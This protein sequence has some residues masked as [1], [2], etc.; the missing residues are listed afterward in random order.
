MK[1][2]TKLTLFTTVSKAVIV[3]LFVGLLPSMVDSV[4]FNYTN[5]LL[6]QQEKKVFTTIEKNGIDYYLEG[7][8]SYGSYTMLKEEYISLEQNKS[9]SLPDTLLTSKRMIEGDTLTYRLLIRNFEYEG[10]SYTLEIGKTLASINQYNR[11]LQRIALYV[12]LVLV[13]LTLIMDLGFTR[14]L[15]RPLKHIIGSKLEAPKF[16][17]NEKLEPIR[18]ST[19]DFR[20]LDQSLINLMH[21]ITEDFERERAFT[22]NA[23]HELM[24]PLGILQGKMENIMLSADDMEV[25]EKTSSMM[26]TLGRLKKIVNALLMISRIENNQYSRQDK[27]SP[28][29]LLTEMTEELGLLMKE[30]EI[31]SDIHLAGNITVQSV[32]QDLLF[33]LFYNLLTNAI[34]YNRK[35][36]RITITGKY[37][38]KGYV[39]T[40]EDTGIGMEAEELVHIFDRFRKSG[41]SGS[42]SNGL[43]L[44]IVKSIAE[45]HGIS[46]QVVSVKDR[47]SQFSVIFPMAMITRKRFK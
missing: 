14:V 10:K 13:V 36:G 44:S 32:N 1:L 28:D 23:S 35:G 9:L 20:Y 47:G 26:K 18:T 12:L 27:V 21:R 42:G 6:R 19:T 25:L 41:S 29:R 24:T 22:S 38:Q 34:R 31:V 30:K 39:V 11:P 46:V 45:F 2:L 5:Y 4:A 40:I 37:I 8:S 17:Y 3:L 7:D 16:P 33:Q 43:G 15:L